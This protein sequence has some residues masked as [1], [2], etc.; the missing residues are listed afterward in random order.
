M[1]AVPTSSASFARDVPGSR[2]VNSGGEMCPEFS[3]QRWATPGRRSFNTYGPTETTVSASLAESSPGQPVTIGTPSPNYG[4]SI[5]GDDGAVSPQGQTGEL[6]ITG[7]GVA[8]GYSG[9]PESTAEKFSAN[10]RPSGD[11]DTRMYRSGDSAR[12]DENGQIQCS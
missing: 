6:C 3:V 9:R 1:H 2:I 5:R 12:I 10:P 7:P 8:G 4:M 11:H